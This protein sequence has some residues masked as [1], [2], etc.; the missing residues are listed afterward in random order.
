MAIAWLDYLRQSHQ[1]A[2]IGSVRLKLRG[3]T[4]AVRVKHELLPTLNDLAFAAPLAQN[5][6][7]AGLCRLLNMPFSN[8]CASL[9]P[10]PIMT[11]I[12][13]DS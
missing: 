11:P 2:A 4:T 10:P 3:D 1:S 5:V 9:Y 8:A 7:N 6:V 13:R 12:Y